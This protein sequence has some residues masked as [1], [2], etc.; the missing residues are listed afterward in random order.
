MVR[1]LRHILLLLIAFA[2]IG[3]TTEQSMRAAGYDPVPMA[4]DNTMSCDMADMADAAATKPMAPCKGDIPDC[5][6]A[7][8]CASIAALPAQFP[9]RETAFRHHVIGYW[10]AASTLTGRQLQPEPLPPRTI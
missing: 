2:L 3:G 7:M 8:C 10:P 4:M 6:K 9:S 5:V 1:N